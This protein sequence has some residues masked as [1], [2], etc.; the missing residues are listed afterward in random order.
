MFDTYLNTRGI[1]HVRQYKSALYP[2]CCDFYLPAYDLYIEI[3]ASWTHGGHPYDAEHDAEKLEY[4]RSKHTRYYDAA[5][6]TWIQRDVKKRETAKLNKL[7]Y[8]EIFSND[9]GECIKQFEEHIKK[10]GS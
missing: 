3:Q 8:L 9:A 4:W 6:E 5:I 2:F 10:E 7:N 1:Q